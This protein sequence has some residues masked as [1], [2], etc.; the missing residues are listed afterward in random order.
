MP[1]KVD[2]KT[3][4][5]KMDNAVRIL[6]EL[7]EEF[8][9]IFSVKP[10]LKTLEAAF[11]QVEARYRL[12]K[13]QQETVL[14]RLVDEGNATD[15]GLSLTIRKIGDK[16]KADFLQ[17]A[18]KF[19]AYQKEQ[20]SSETSSEDS[21]ILEA[22]T[23]SM[24]SMTSAVAKMADTLGSKPTLSGL[25]RLPVPTWDG[26]RRS[27]ATWKKEFNTW[28]TKYGQ[29]KDEQL[30]RFRNSMPKGSWWTDQVKT[31]KTIDSA[32]NILDTEFADRRKLMDELLSEINNLKPIKRDSKSF[33]HFATTIACY[34]NDMEDN[35]CPV[36]ESSEAPFLMSQLLSKLDPNDNS[37]FGR[38]MKREGKEE[39]VSNLISWLHQE[40]S[41]RSRGKTNT[42]SEGRNESRRDKGPK[43]TENNAADSEE[44]GDETCPLGCK[45]KHH[46]AACPK[47]QFL[48]VN[49]K[50]EIVK[51]HWRCRKCLRAHH[52][53][54]CKKPDGSTC[55]KCRKNHHRTLHNERTGETNTSLNPRAAPF[56]SQFQGPSTTSNGSVQGN[57]VY[58]KSK[59]K[60]VTGLCPVQKVKVMNRNGNFVEVLAMLDSG[61][62]TS[63]LSKTAARRLGLNGVPTHLTMN[64]AGGK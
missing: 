64:L 28:M 37:D 34:V 14:D 16:V 44:T 10:E 3:L 15:E 26:G 63:L 35:G 51:Q 25:Q 19:A 42:F 47:F 23:S 27:Y 39:T 7:I 40:A 36:L 54:D 45:T 41:I 18:L 52:T 60:P 6:D 29:D 12:I 31:C 8:E 1:P 13:K 49:Q 11:N 21:A 33:T 22:L 55:D 24:S 5:G 59:L 20:N 32:W 56:Q 9:I 43:R 50:W 38:E 61:S 4:A 46:L 30:Q 62:N 58:Q 17:I 2:V 57:A 48:T 53:N